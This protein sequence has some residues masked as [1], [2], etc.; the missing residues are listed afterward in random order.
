[1]LSGPDVPVV[2]VSGDNA[3]LDVVRE[4]AART[5]PADIAVLFA[6]AART[7][8]LDGHLTL[9]SD[10]A[11][12]AAQVLGAAVVIPVHAEGWGHFT[13]GTGDLTAA[14]ARHGEAGRLAVL[15]PGDSL[16]R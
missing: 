2:Y 5:G 11:A 7:P 10:Q 15:A 3:S 14:F 4:I 12:R 9:T 8:L 16:T 1:V 13:E 6:G